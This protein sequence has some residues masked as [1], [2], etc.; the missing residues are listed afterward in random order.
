MALAFDLLEI[1]AEIGVGDRKFGAV[2]PRAYTATTATLSFKAVEPN[3]V[4]GLKFELCKR[5]CRPVVFKLDLPEKLK[6]NRSES[7]P[8]LFLITV[9]ALV[10]TVVFRLDNTPEEFEYSQPTYMPSPV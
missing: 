1:K 5:D 10:L 7:T 2:L 3:L 9:L 8:L 4:S 6:I